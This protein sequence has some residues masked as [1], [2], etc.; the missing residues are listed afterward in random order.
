[1]PTGVFIL[2]Y[3]SGLKCASAEIIVGGFETAEEHLRRR[4]SMNSE[5]GVLWRG[6]S[7]PGVEFEERQFNTDPCFHPEGGGELGGCEFTS[8][9]SGNHENRME[10]D[11]MARVYQNHENCIRLT[12]IGNSI[13]SVFIS[14]YGNSYRRKPEKRD[15]RNLYQKLPIQGVEAAI[16]EPRPPVR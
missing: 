15:S 5:T 14:G 11:E 13:T 12:S 8:G 6:S 2:V 3:S 7:T 9:E 16:T 1:M 4:K 10:N